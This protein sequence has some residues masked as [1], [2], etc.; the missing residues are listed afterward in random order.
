MTFNFAG[1]GGGAAGREGS[2]ALHIEGIERFLEP[3]DIKV[4][5]HRRAAQRT[6]RRRGDGAA[7]G[8][9]RAQPLPPD[10]ACAGHVGR[11]QLAQS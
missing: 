1:E 8:A 10:P 11:R 6:N 5:Q 3:G 2:V 9:P 4:G 7:D